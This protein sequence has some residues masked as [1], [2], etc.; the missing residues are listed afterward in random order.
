MYEL[1]K[2]KFPKFIKAPGS[3]KIEKGFL[4]RILILSILVSSLFGFLAG[5]FFSYYFYQEV[6]DYLSELDIEIPETEKII[7]KHITEKEYIPQTTQE[8]KIIKVVEENAPA[9]VSIIITKDVPV[10]E[11][12]FIDPFGED[13]PFE[14]QIPEYRQ[15]GF[16]KQEI[17]GG[18]GF[19]ISKDGMIL[20]NKHVV[21]DKEADYT[22]FTNDG[23][24][25]PA[26]VLARDP[27]QDLAIIKIQG[28][29][30]LIKEKPFIMVK[31]GNS[32]NL[33]IGQTVIAIGNALGE[34][35]NTISVGVISG[36]GRTITASGGGLVE[37]L[38]DVIQTDAA[39]NK[40]NSGGPLLNLKGEV[41]GINTATV[42][43]AQSIGF[44]I[45]VNNAKKDIEQVK[46]IGKIVYPF[47]GVRYVLIN[48]KIKEEQGLSVDY[49]I[50]IVPGKQGES[51]IFPDSPAETAGL[52]EGDIILEFNN[53]KIS[54]SN[55]L[56]KIILKHNPGDKVK[57]K[58]LSGDKERTIWVIL[59]ERE[60]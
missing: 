4:F 3:Q 25:F 13:W 60:E 28:N 19:I 22:V 37:I 39:I 47:L 16:E 48:E 53:E 6:K 23:R 52:K 27:V 38:E 58:I 11:Q 50:L 46:A 34:F 42:I 21:L 41:I 2:L 26:K 57:L 51:A 17:G 24:S 43:G 32:S 30:K 36:L 49:G 45:P 59:S 18:T 31:L 7:E 5:G 29:E 8:E 10:I 35:R 1:P 54:I 56:A 44:A 33:Q 14:I 12:Y 20:T 40:G 55:S 15:K 9:V